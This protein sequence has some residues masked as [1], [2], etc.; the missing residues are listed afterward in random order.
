M[1]AARAALASAAASAG[2]RLLRASAAASEAFERYEPP[3]ARIA[4]ELTGV[5]RYVRLVQ[6]AAL[7][8]SFFRQAALVAAL[9]LLRRWELHLRRQRRRL[10][11]LQEQ[12]NLLEREHARVAGAAVAQEQ[13][14]LQL[15]L[16][17]P[18]VGILEGE[19]E[20]EGEDPALDDPPPAAAERAVARDHPAGEAGGD[21]DEEEERGNRRR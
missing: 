15:Q 12:L 19:G 7:A 3:A 20:E 6:L 16:P 5:L 9:M 17:D 13:L 21:D 14:L 10:N 8:H 1:F 18:A 4:A 11:D 2:P